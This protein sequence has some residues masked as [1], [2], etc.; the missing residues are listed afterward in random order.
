MS[1]QEVNLGRIIFMW[2]SDWEANKQYYLYDIVRVEKV[3]LF[4]CKTP[5]ISS[6]ETKPREESDL[7]SLAFDFNHDLQINELGGIPANQYVTL[8]YL[9]QHINTK[10]NNVE[11]KLNNNLTDINNKIAKKADKSEVTSSAEI[12]NRINTAK[13]ALQEQLASSVNSAKTE[14]ANQTDTKINAAKSEL[15]NAISKKANSADIYTRTE[16]DNRFLGINAKAKDSDK[17]DGLDS[18][19]FLKVADFNNNASV[20]NSGFQVRAGN[21]GNAAFE[22]TSGMDYVIKVNFGSAFQ[23]KCLFVIVENYNYDDSKDGDG[24]IDARTV[25]LSG[26]EVSKTGF[27]SKKIERSSAW[28]YLAFGY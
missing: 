5:H 22:R 9:T 11:T 15:N 20:Q 10:I 12:N 2:K 18:T 19:A 23:N 28:N 4:F 21:C 1:L 13:T 25:L 24:F 14:I 27:A 6:D 7:W 3:G 8:E 26:A 16:C 17:L